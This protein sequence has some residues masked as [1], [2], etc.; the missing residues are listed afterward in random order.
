M[1]TRSSDDLKFFLL[2]IQSDR[3]IAVARELF[4]DSIRYV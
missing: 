3:R 1:A 2:N 4:V